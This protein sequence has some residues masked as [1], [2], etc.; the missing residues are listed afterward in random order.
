MFMTYLV[1]G[2]P[3][4]ANFETT[5]VEMIGIRLLTAHIMIMVPSVE[6]VWGSSDD[7]SKFTT[8][9]TMAKFHSLQ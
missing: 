4:S 2:L 1:P 5:R 3:A 7:C 6:N 9:E 8:T